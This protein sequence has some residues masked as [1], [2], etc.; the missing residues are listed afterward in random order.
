M[1]VERYKENPIIYPT[2]KFQATFNPAAIL[3]DNRVLLYVRVVEDYCTYMSRIDLYEGDG[4]NFKKLYEGIIVPDKYYDCMGCEDPRAVVLDG[5]VYITYTGLS[6]PALVNPDPKA[7]LAECENPYDIGTYKKLGP[8]TNVGDK[9]VVLFPEKI[10]GKY[11]MLHRPDDKNIYIS[12]SDD[13]KNWSEPK[14]LIK[15]EYDWEEFKIG[16]GCPPV[17][18]EFGWIVIYHG[19]SDFVYRAGLAVLD[20]NEPW[21]VIYKHPDPIWEPKEWYEKYGDV[22][23]VVFPTGAI[24]K[25]GKLWI[26][27]GTADKYVSLAFLDLQEIKEYLK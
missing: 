12:F 19:V 13:L 6:K 4:I 10:N 26:Y 5:K 7:I 11:A 17:K 20:L 18:T 16:A 1:Q 2:K 23:N 8:I 3:Y 21:K 27:A 15:K 9:D 22:P 14:L 24:I 25:D